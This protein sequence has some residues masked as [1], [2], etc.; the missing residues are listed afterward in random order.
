MLFRSKGFSIVELLSTCSTNWGV[1]PAAALKWL[2]E[3]M[4]PEFPLGV[5]KDEEGPSA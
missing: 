5:F 1:T 3:K 2:E 4:L